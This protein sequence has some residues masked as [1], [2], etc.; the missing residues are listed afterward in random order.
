MCDTQKNIRIQCT[1]GA[2]SLKGIFFE[3]VVAFILSFLCIYIISLVLDFAFLSGGKS[4]FS[5]EKLV[6]KIKSKL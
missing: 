1:G 6:E 3:A 2:F 4:S 5:F